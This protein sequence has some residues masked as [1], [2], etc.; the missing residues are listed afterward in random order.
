[1]DYYAQARTSYFEVKNVEEFK[2]IARIYNASVFTDE[3]T[4]A[5]AL[6]FSDGIPTFYVPQEL[7]EH[8]LC[9]GDEDAD[10][11]FKLLASMLQSD[12]VAVLIEV[13]YE[14]MRYLAAFAYLLTPEGQVQAID[15]YDG[16]AK[17]LESS[18]FG[19]LKV[20]RMSY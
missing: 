9:D 6:A 7:Q 17:E 10:F 18:M 19:N 11:F 1:M 12:Q 14:G 2:R 13:G 4:N 20:G 16:I 3:K 15:L 8:P 5:V